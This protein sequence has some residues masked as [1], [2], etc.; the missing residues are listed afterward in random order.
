MDILEHLFDTTNID[1]DIITVVYAIIGYN[2]PFKY[3]VHFDLVK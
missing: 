2:E 3:T 1:K